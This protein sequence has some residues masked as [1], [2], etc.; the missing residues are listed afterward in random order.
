[1]LFKE[2]KAGYSI[3]IFDKVNAVFTT[4]NVTNVTPPH[5]DP[6]YSP[7]QMVVDVFVENTQKPYSIPDGIDTCFQSNLIISTDRDKILREVEALQDQAQ[8]IWDNRETYREFAEKC[9]GIRAEHSPEFK[10]KRE[11]EERFNKLEDSVND[12]KD[13]IKGLVKELKG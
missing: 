4:A 12:L 13:M 8:K 5:Y 1:M 9:A 10:E 2:L 11:N 7:T 3:F 6:H